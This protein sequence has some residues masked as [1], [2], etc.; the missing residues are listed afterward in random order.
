VLRITIHDNP[1]SLT[2]QLEGKLEG[3]WVRE[4]A[5]CWQRTVELLRNNRKCKRTKDI[6][7][8]DFSDVCPLPSSF[9]VDR[10]PY[11]ATTLMAL[12]MAG[13]E[14]Q[15]DFVECGVGSDLRLRSLVRASATPGEPFLGQPVLFPDGPGGAVAAEVMLPA[16]DDD[17]SEVL[18]L[19]AAVLG[20]AVSGHGGDGSPA[21]K[22][23]R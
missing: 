1:T 4:L 5:A 8:T 22:H 12:G 20:D 14:R 17:Q 7:Q 9:C 19:V 11:C 21:G 2:F 13:P 10:G 3:P 15:D 6:G 23:Y 18:R 16:V